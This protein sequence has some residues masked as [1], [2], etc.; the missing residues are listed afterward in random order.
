MKKSEEPVIVEQVFNTSL[1][2][3]W[4]AITDLNQMKQWYF[5]NIKSFKP[6]VGFETSFPVKSGG[7]TFTHQWKITEVIP[8][9]KI[10][11]R[12]NYKEYPGDGF[13]MFEISEVPNGTKL[14]LTNIV[15]EDF[16][17]EIPEFRSES[18]VNGWNYF[19]KE[20]LKNYLGKK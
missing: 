6:E 20:R 7:R 14:K 15:T 11:Y 17:D 10:V 16:P 2:N 4:D 3:V 8:V 18:A 13:V 19:I 12:W 1:E 9:K 5:E